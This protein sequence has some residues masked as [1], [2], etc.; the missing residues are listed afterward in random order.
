MQLRKNI[1]SVLKL[2]QHRLKNLG[3]S[4]EQEELFQGVLLYISDTSLSSFLHIHQQVEETVGG[5]CIYSAY[6]IGYRL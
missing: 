4:S 5:D 2:V 1:L 6:T 3:A